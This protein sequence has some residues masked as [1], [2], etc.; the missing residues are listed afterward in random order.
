[1]Q[2]RELFVQLFEEQMILF[3]DNLADFIGGFLWLRVKSLF[4]TKPPPSP[5]FMVI[6]SVGWVE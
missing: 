1:L 6:S 3:T 5:F 4:L 2:F